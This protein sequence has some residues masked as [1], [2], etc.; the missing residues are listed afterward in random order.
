M[1]KPSVMDNAPRASGEH[2]GSPAGSELGCVWLR[3]LIRYHPV[4]G[5][6]AAKV[7]F[8]ERGISLAR[9]HQTV[10]IPSEGRHAHAFA[11]IRDRIW[12]HI[13]DIAVAFEHVGSTSVLR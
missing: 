1:V 13:S 2:G 5:E 12:P 10:M 11:Q 9:L 3:W 4:A 8:G 7:S 6:V